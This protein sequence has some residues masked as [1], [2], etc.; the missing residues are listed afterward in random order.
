MPSDFPIYLLIV[1]L[2]F[3]IA[4][5]VIGSH[6]LWNVGSCHTA[7]ISSIPDGYVIGYVENARK[8]EAVTIA[9]IRCNINDKFHLFAFK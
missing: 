7:F 5:Y 6:E 1:Q 4:L 9:F 8:S 3:V 2:G